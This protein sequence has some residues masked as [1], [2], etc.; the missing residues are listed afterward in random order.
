MNIR[1]ILSK[2][3]NYWSIVA[4]ENKK[5]IYIGALE[6]SVIPK[7]EQIRNLI[8]AAVRVGMDIVEKNKNRSLVEKL[9]GCH[10]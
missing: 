7:E 1:T 4:L 3:K 5:E 10:E 6:T 9:G 8:D 2:D